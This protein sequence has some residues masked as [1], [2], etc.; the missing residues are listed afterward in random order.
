MDKIPHPNALEVRATNL[1]EEWRRFKQRF[2]LLMSATGADEKPERQKASI[3]LTVVGEDCMPIYN[4]FVWD[5]AG[6]EMILQ[7]IID[8]FEAYCVPKRSI[9][10]ERY[11]FFTATP[12]NGR[13]V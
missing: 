7:M 2:V 11:K 3:F 12:R 9:T 10:Y 5:K 4:S 8:K 1:A 6:D 13:T